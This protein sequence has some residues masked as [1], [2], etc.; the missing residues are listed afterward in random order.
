MVSWALSSCPRQTPGPQ[1]GQRRLR[2]PRRGRARLFEPLASTGRPPPSST[3]RLGGGQAPHQ[4]CEARCEAQRPSRHRRPRPC[5][6]RPRRR[7]RRRPMRRARSLSTAHWASRVGNRRGPRRR[8]SIVVKST[9]SLALCPRR[10]RR[11]IASSTG[12]L[13]ATPGKTRS[14]FGAASTNRSD[15]RW[16]LSRNEPARAGLARRLVVWAPRPPLLFGRAHCF[17]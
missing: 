7:R 14:R 3:R 4:R 13:G 9:A 10:P 1:L 6:H 17:D 2:R 15:A 8:S 16:P 12:P 5:R 11:G